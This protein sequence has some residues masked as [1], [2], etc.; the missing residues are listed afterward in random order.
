MKGL[1]ARP[2]DGVVC[3]DSPNAPPTRCTPP[4]TAGTRPTN[5]EVDAEVRQGSSLEAPGSPSLPSVVGNTGEGPLPRADKLIKQ[6]RGAKLV[7]ELPGPG[8]KGR[9]GRQ[10]S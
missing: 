2:H 6:G 1:K 5:T 7:P 8:T 10:H 3:E 4:S 9:P